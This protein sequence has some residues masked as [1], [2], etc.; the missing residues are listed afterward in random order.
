[1]DHYI[2]TYN[3]SQILDLADILQGNHGIL[4]YYFHLDTNQLTRVIYINIY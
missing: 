2:A 4:N 3:L 1:M